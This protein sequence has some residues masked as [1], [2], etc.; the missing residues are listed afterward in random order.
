MRRVIEF[1]APHTVPDHQRFR[2]ELSHVE[3]L[4]SEMLV[5][6]AADTAPGA[7]RGHPPGRRGRGHLRPNAEGGASRRGQLV[8]PFEPSAT[9]APGE[10]IDVAFKPGNLHFFDL[11]TGAALR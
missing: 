2:A 4:G 8:A 5:H 9:P 7:E 6:L 10:P 11:A 3:A 1:F